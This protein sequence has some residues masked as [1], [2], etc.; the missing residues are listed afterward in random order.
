MNNLDQYTALLGLQAGKYASIEE[1]QLIAFIKILAY[2]APC[3]VNDPKNEFL[4]T[5]AIKKMAAPMLTIK[6]NEITEVML[7]VGYDIAINPERVAAWNIRRLDSP[8]KV[9]YEN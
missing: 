9:K 4:T 7:A 8:V 3:S 1:S 2:F 5:D 6:V